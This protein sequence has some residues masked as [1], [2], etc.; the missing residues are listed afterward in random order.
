MMDHERCMEG[1]WEPP[2][3]DLVSLFSPLVPSRIVMKVEKVD[4]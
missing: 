3:P 1:R 2:A 4:G